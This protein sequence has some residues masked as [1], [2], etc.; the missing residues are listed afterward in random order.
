MPFKSAIK[1]IYLGRL[2]A[3]LVGNNNKGIKGANEITNRVGQ[4]QQRDTGYE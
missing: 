3:F 2:L 4:K 1:G